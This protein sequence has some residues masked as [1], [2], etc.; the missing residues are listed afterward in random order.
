M[1]RRASWATWSTATLILLP[2]GRSIRPLI[3]G[4]AVRV[5]T[6]EPPVI[7]IAG[8]IVSTVRVWDEVALTPLAAETTTTTG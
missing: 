7:T 6:A 5:D 2:A 1:T 4:V 3:V 8:A